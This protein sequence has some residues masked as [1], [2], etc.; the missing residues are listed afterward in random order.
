VGAGRGVQRATRVLA[1]LLAAGADEHTN[2]QIHSS[3]NARS[4]IHTYM[5]TYILV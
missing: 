5:H 3:S 2:P 1:R 4:I